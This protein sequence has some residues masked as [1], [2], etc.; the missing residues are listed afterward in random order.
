MP[1][2]VLVPSSLRATCPTHAG[3]LALRQ[4]WIHFA[5]EKVGSGTNSETC[6]EFQELVKAHNA[7]YTK[8]NNNFMEVDL[9]SEK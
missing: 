3:N 7:V 6:G 2:Q 4:S 1:A 5:G 8:S 9:T